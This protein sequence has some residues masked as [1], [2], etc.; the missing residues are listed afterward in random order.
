MVCQPASR[1]WESSGSFKA[2]SATPLP[3]RSTVPPSVWMGRKLLATCDGVASTTMFCAGALAQN[4]VVDATPS[5]V[6]NSFRPIQ[7]LGG[8]VDR[9][10]NG[11]AEHA[12]KEPLLSQILDAGWQTITY[13]QNTEL[14]AEA[15][16]WNS[17]GTWSDAA[18]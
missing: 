13:R 14:F 17:E 12:L 6:A 18:N 1:I 7:T 8:T 16:H 5:H 4:I 3:R 15:W 9:L 11:V 2:C 10:G